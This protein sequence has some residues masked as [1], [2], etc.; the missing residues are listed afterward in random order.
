[1][2][3][4]K[5][6]NNRC[7]P[8]KV[9]EK[10][11]YYR[12][13]ESTVAEFVRRFPDTNLRVVDIGAR[14]GYA[15]ELLAR[16]GYN[17]VGVELINGFVEHAVKH[18]RNVIL[19]DVMDSTLAANSFDVVYSRHCIEHCRDTRVFLETCM[20]I[21]A[22]SGNVFFT[23]PLENRQQFFSRKYPR[24][25][26]MVYFPNKGSF[27]AIAQEVGLQEIEFCKSKKYGII[28]DGREVLYVGTFAK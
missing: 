5:H 20:R 7:V 27:R 24:L 22:N 16:A 4:I 1:M 23:F 15:V 3:I 13:T 2:P 8:V 12:H 11:K 18:N 9:E 14:D 28:P 6:K 21:L 26:H 17:V 25:N 10:T 19:D